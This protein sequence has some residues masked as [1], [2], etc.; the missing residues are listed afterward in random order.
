VRFI[1]PS[2]MSVFHAFRSRNWRSICFAPRYEIHAPAFVT[3]QTWSVVTLP[4][5]MAPVSEI[6]CF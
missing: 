3:S 2:E 4:F 5:W 1:S 6:E